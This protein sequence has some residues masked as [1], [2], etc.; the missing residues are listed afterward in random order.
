MAVFGHISAKKFYF[1]MPF[2]EMLKYDLFFRFKPL[3]DKTNANFFLKVPKTSKKPI[4]GH[5]LAKIWPKKFFFE[6]PALSLFFNYFSLIH[7]RKSEKPYGGKYENLRHG[8]TD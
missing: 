7:W 2:F 4:F 3:P 8:Q 1:D 5:I 6:N